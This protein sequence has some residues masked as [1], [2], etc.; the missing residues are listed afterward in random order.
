LYTTLLVLHT[1]QIDEYMQAQ[2]HAV[3]RISQDQPQ[4]LA[5]QLTVEDLAG[6]SK[7]SHA[8]SVMGKSVMTSS[9]MTT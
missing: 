4:A 8:R 9:R 6:W 1:L 3:K 5:E 7:V 2:G